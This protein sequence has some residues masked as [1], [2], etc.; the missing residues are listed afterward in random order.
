MASIDGL[1][2]GLNTTQIISSLMAVERQSGRYLTQGKSTSQS[3]VSVLQGLNSS[4]TSLQTAALAFAPDS[5]TQTS[6]W[7]STTASSS[8]TAAATATTTSGATAG[9][10]TFTVT[11]LATAAAAVSTGTVAS[12]G[13]A[14]A[15]GPLLLTTGAAAIGLRG[16]EPG[17]ALASGAH[18]LAVAQA[19]AGATLTGTS[20]LA[21]TTILDAT[22]NTISVYLD[23]SPTASTFTLTAGSYTTAQ[24]AAEVT[25]ASGGAL[26]AS[27]GTDGALSLATTHEGSAA[28]ARLA[29]ANTALGLTDTASVAIGTDAVIELDGVGTTLSSLTA[30]DEVTLAGANGDSVR[31]TLAGGVRAGTATATQVDLAP[32]ATLAD[33]VSA[34]NRSGAGVKAAAIQVSADAYRL[35]LTSSS[36]G[37]ATGITLDAGAFPSGL[38]GLGGTAELQAGTDTVLHVGTGPGA[39]DVVSSTTSVSGLLPGVTITAAKADPST[40]VTV[41]VKED[42]SGIADKM[43]ALVGAA[44]SV[45]S[46]IG[47][48]SGYQADTKSAGALLGNSMAR[49]LAQR[50]TTGVIGTAAAP[51][52]LS[53]VQVTRDGA[54][55]FD[56]EAF[57]AAYDKDP[58]GVTASLT[59]MAQ[60]LA[61]TAK[62]ASD[63]H[64]GFVT[65]Q[66]DLEQQRVTDYTHQIA[67]FED[68]MTLRQQTLQR[69]YTALE[70]MLGTLQSRSQWLAGQIA[71]LPTPNTSTK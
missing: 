63:P 18:T 42:T 19:S 15:D 54:V 13:T 56:R 51:P 6:A 43:Q 25:R 2:S 41:T 50:V 23:G 58:A 62:A 71:S 12:T 70:T 16:V 33:V 31:A 30:G 68:R 67:D 46:Y 14:V 48:K 21:A 29:S 28:S 9:S 34:V 22:N 57:L 3:L 4:V 52:S 40:S 59:A 27:V 47:S 49:D 10:T 45:L 44:N 8:N 11:G 61:A 64:G 66:I 36:T 26:A 7:A 55:T 24:L 1:V 65:G 5:V 20:S 39:Y 53:G 69:Q 60:S 32:N 37:S 38:S 35:Q 17:S